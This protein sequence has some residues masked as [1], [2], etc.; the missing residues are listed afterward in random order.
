MP[1]AHRQRYRCGPSVTVAQATAVVT[2]TDD[3]IDDGNCK[4]RDDVTTV[5]ASA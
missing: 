5:N 3:R 2:A 1:A 4:I